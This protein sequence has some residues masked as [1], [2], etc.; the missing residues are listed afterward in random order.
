MS[1]LLLVP[2]QVSCFEL[3]GFATHSLVKVLATARKQAKHSHTQLFEVCVL[4]GRDAAMPPSYSAV[5]GGVAAPIMPVA[6]CVC[7]SQLE[8]RALRACWG[9]LAQFEAFSFGR[10]ALSPLLSRACANETS[11]PCRGQPMFPA[12]PASVHTVLAM[13]AKTL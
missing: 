3:V 5:V 12:G 9:R 7:V 4:C 8:S 13:G 2:S 11:A 6:N 1:G 10:C